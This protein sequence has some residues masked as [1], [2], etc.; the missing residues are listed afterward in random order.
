MY[1]EIVQLNRLETNQLI[2]I[3][4]SYITILFVSFYILHC[5]SVCPVFILVT[6]MWGCGLCF[7][8]DYVVSMTCDISDG[9][10]FRHY[11]YAFF[12]RHCIVW[13][14][15]EHIC[16]CVSTLNTPE[17]VFFQQRLTLTSVCTVN[18]GTAHN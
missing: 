18:L 11:H 5:F 13:L 3:N 14:Q 16:L 7:P 8:P 4:Q 2:K 17:I 15:L 9:I 12:T 1:L 6:G 10:F